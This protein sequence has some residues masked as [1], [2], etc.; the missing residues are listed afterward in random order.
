MHKKLVEIIEE[1]KVEVAKLKSERIHPPEGLIPAL[2]D[3]KSAISKPGKINLIAEIK[4]AS[5]SAGLIREKTDPTNIGITYERAGASAISLL[6]DRKF[7]Q[8]DIACLPNLKM[9]VTLPILRKDFIIDEIQLL[10]AS[11][12]GADAALLIA[13]ILT[14]EQ[15]KDLIAACRGLGLIPLTEIHDMNDLEKSLKCGADIIGINNRD[16][17]TFKIDMNT[18]FI[19][20][21]FIPEECVVVGESGINDERDIEALKGTRVN[22]VLIGSALMKSHDIGASATKIV[23]AGQ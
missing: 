23:K 16:L 21:P 11:F 9:A 2:R 15:L 4:F 6:T 3:F 5:P 13:R 10:E 14:A 1:K 8:G 12:Y 7:F 20:A 17:D 22:A 18:T 19:I